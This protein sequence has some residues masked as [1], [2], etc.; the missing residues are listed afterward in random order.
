MP[1]RKMTPWKMTSNSG[2]EG[3]WNYQRYYSNPSNP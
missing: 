1:M 2:G 3:K